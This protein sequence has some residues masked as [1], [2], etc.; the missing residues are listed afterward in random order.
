MTCLEDMPAWLFRDNPDKTFTYS[1][2][3]TSD[4]QEVIH[5]VTVHFPD[6]QPPNAFS[7]AVE[8]I[9][10]TKKTA[11]QL[12]TVTY[13]ENSLSWYDMKYRKGKESCPTCTRFI[14]NSTL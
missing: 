12:T 6:I 10:P 1:I 4:T 3:D 2:D 14:Y 9:N 13:G 7:E 5:R 8:F 11:V